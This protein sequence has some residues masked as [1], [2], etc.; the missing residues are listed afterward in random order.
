MLQVSRHKDS[1]LNKLPFGNS[2]RL[3]GPGSCSKGR[4]SRGA[5]T[6]SRGI[7]RSASVLTGIGVG[8]AVQSLRVR[9][10]N[11]LSMKCQ[12]SKSGDEGCRLTHN[13]IHENVGESYAHTG[14]IP[15]EAVSVPFAL[16]RASYVYTHD[17]YP[18]ITP[19]LTRED[20]LG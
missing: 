3:I 7:R 13:R 10:Y 11:S 20:C 16:G 14:F 15:G 19:T 5:P 4:S 8:L 2:Q 18:A 17:K 12:L 1:V 9:T 6:Y